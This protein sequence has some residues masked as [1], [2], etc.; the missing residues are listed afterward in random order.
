MIEIR[1]DNE[2]RWWSIYGEIAFKAIVLHKQ[3]QL[4]DCRQGEEGFFR[5]IR[6]PFPHKPRA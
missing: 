5:R 6:L 4:D 1:G 3:L 2:V